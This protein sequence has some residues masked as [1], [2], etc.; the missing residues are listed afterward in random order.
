MNTEI[1]LKPEYLAT[2]KEILHRHLPPSATVWLFGSR[3]KGNAKKYSDIDLLIDLNAPISIKI[4][5]KLSLAFEESDLPYK[6]DL[7]DAAAISEAF[8]KNIQAQLIL[9]E[10]L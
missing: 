1:D 2:V 6:V 7:A 10:I 5:A 8:R 9:L 4:M 3:A